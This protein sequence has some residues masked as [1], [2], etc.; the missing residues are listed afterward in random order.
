MN[1]SEKL[2]DEKHEKFELKTLVKEAEE[3]RI[4]NNRV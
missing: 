2:D 3:K 1:L 4:I